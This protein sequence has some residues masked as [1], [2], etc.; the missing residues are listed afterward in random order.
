[1]PKQRK[2][3]TTG[4]G[5][6][7]GR[8]FSSKATM[9]SDAGGGC[10]GKAE[11]PE[12]VGFVGIEFAI[13]SCKGNS[14]AAEID[15]AERLVVIAGTSIEGRTVLDLGGHNQLIGTF[16]ITRVNED[17]STEYFE[18]KHEIAGNV[19]AALLQGI[20]A[21]D[22]EQSVIV[23]PR[24][25]QALESSY[26][27]YR[28]ESGEAVPCMTSTVISFEDQEGFLAIPQVLAEDLQ[29]DVS[30]GEFTL[31]AHVRPLSTDMREFAREAS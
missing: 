24:P 25:G 6:I 7:N 31:R 12:W 11:L 13:C 16:T 1:M 4:T 28:L 10:S 17:D 26:C 19:D 21:K 30:S 14:L 9:T 8:D 20:S 29:I 18:A 22:P 3:T 5:T 15:E 27:A 2:M 23:C